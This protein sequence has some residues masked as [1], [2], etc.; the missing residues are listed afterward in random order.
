MTA[1][2]TTVLVKLLAT[3]DELF[4]GPV[5]AELRLSDSKKH[6]HTDSTL[7]NA[8]Q[9][10]GYMANHKLKTILQTQCPATARAKNYICQHSG[11]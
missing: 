11:D 5:V 1:K 10:L 7:E 2:R 3:G 9:Y 6:I 8:R 4:C